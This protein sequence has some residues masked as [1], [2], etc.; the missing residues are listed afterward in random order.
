MCL[1]ILLA[2]RYFRRRFRNTRILRTHKSLDGVRALAVPRRE[3]VPVCRPFRLAS[4]LRL[5]RDREWTVGGFFMTKPSLTS[6]RTSWPVRFEVK[7]LV[8]GLLTR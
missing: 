1:S 5:V 2:S 6:F 7:T 8:S 3:P 4:S